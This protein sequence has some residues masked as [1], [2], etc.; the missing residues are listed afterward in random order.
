MAG[1][2]CVLNGKKITKKFSSEA[3]KWRIIGFGLNL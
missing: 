2:K 3:P 1:I